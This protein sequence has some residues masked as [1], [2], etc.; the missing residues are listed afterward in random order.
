MK[1]GEFY[2]RGVHVQNDPD[3]KSK[4]VVAKFGELAGLLRKAA[5]I[6]KEGPDYFSG[7]VRESGPAVD[8]ADPDSNP[9]K[10]EI[11]YVEELADRADFL[12][13][14]IGPPKRPRKR[15]PKLA[16]KAFYWAMMDL[17]DNLGLKPGIARPTEGQANYPGHPFE[18]FCKN[19][20]SVI[21]PEAK[22]LSKTMIGIII[23]DW[24]APHTNK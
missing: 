17:Y 13:R 10:P 1:A 12:F 19:W 22:P 15:P 8:P 6:M 5:D 16:L 11:E 2:K 4:S 7:E 3:I 21:A 24:D 20:L 18:V 14:V 9:S 23:K